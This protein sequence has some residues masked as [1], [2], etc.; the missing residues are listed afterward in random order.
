MKIKKIALGMAIVASFSINAAN[1]TD[2]GHG[3]VTF[4]GSIIDAPCSISPD[5]TDQTVNL[6]EVSDKALENGG[7]STPQPFNIRLENCDTTQLKNVNV[8]FTGAADADA[9]GM[10]GITGSASGAGIV[11]TDGSGSPITLGTPTGG[12]IIQDGNNTL[13]FS[14]YLQGNG[15]SATVVPGDFQ[16]VTDFTLAYN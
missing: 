1:A 11:L 16:G 4:T 15:A 8:T 6:G 7:K 14:A 13:T 2:Q 10:L 3:T 9:P 12:Q 5:T